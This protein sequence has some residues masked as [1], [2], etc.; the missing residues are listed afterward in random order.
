MKHVYRNKLILISNHYMY[1]RKV[2]LLFLQLE[3]S[4]N[5]TGVLK[6]VIFWPFGL[7]VFSLNF[8]VYFI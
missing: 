4:F 6:F 8:E 5:D 3:D 2:V 1:Q 7:L